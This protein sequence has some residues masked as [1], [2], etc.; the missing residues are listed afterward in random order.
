MKQIILTERDFDDLVHGRIVLRQGVEIV[1]KEIDFE[2]T[3]DCIYAALE[4]N[5][6]GKKTGRKA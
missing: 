3:M 4:E 1:L 6:V 2:K 5:A